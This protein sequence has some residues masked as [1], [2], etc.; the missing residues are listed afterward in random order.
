MSRDDIIKMLKENIRF[1]QN[2]AAHYPN[3]ATNASAAMAAA[4]ALLEEDKRLLAVAD[5]AH[6]E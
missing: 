6:A 1:M 2:V 4:A 3:T 5:T